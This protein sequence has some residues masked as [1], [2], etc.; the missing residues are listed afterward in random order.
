MSYR[1]LTQALGF[2]LLLVAGI[3]LATLA[4]WGQVLLWQAL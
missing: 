4:W 2:A 1:W 3:V